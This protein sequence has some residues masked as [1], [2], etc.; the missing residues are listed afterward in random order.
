MFYLVCNSLETRNK[1]IKYLHDKKI[2][3]VFHY[4]SLHH[5]P[6]YTSKHDGRE[7]LLS[8][9]YTDCLLRLPLHYELT[10]E[11]VELI[12]HEI[13]IFYELEELH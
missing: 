2:H 5:S 9:K 13:H 3:T 7:L 11:D 4:L 1:L 8:D 6:Y 10:V 12:C